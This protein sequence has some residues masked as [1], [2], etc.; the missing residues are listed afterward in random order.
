MRDVDVKRQ[1]ARQIRLFMEDGERT[2]LIV[3]L[4][5]LEPAEPWQHQVVPDGRG[6]GMRVCT[7]CGRTE[8]TDDHPCVPR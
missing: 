8:P 6:A 2:R 1:V 5:L 4:A 3:C 7:K